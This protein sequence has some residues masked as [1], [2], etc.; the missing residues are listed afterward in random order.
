[1]ENDEFHSSKKNIL[2]VDVLFIDELSMISCRTFNKIEF[3]FRKVRNVNKPF[4]GIQIILTGDLQ[5]SPEP[6]LE[7]GDDG[8]LLI[9]SSLMDN[10]HII[11][12]NEIHRQMNHSHILMVGRKT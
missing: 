9:A 8:S 7:Y 4:G 1:M 5:L 12:L 10:F 11:K 3:L 6:N 2:T